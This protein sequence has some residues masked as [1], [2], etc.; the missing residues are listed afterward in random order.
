MSLINQQNLGK[1]I[2]ADAAMNSNSLIDKKIAYNY[3]Y[4]LLPYLTTTK[5][6]YAGKN[7]VL[8]INLQLGTSQQIVGFPEDYRQCDYLWIEP[9]IMTDGNDI[10]TAF[11]SSDE[12]TIHDI[13]TGQ[14]KKINN[15]DQFDNSL[16]CYDTKL[17]ENLSYDE[18]YQGSAEKNMNILQTD[19]FYYLVKR[20]KKKSLQSPTQTAVLVFD[21]SLKHIG[22]KILAEEVAPRI[23]FIYD[24]Q[25]AIYSYAA[26]CFYLYDI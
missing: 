8:K 21:Q 6:N 1:Y 9:M 7:A 12:I 10:I 15:N 19:S 25:L 3:P 16:T 24:G 18:K 2:P 14:R 13:S 4:L 22:T 23:S 26:K 20:L 17:A 11:P 5:H